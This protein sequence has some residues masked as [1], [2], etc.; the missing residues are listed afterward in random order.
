MNKT[1]T[2]SIDTLFASL[3]VPRTLHG[4]QWRP[5]ARSDIIRSWR[6]F[7]DGPPEDFKGLD[8]TYPRSKFVLNTRDLSEWLDSRFQ[9]VTGRQ[10]EGLL[11]PN[12]HYWRPTAEAV[13]LW[14]RH[15]DRHHL[16]V[17]EYFKDRPNDLLIVNF[18]SD[19]Q[20]AAKI[21]AFLGKKPPAE[22]PYT[23]STKKTRDHGVLVNAEIIESVLNKMGIPQ[24]EWTNDLYCPSLSGQQPFPA[25]TADNP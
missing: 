6:A 21:A 2:S 25:R 5:A 15:R 22:K 19:P 8:Q 3:G 7:T 13:E 11:D 20:A 10:E 12:N 1:A 4:E 14:V 9:H 24:E 17:M 23:R 16:E 18:I